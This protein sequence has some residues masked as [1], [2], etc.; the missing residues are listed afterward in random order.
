MQESGN[1][2]QERFFKKGVLDFDGITILVSVSLFL[3]KYFA[4]TGNHYSP[5]E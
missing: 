2:Q 5:Y 4:G 1:D 3:K